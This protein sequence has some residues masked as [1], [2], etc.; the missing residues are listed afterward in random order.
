MSNIHLNSNSLILVCD[1]KLAR[2]KWLRGYLLRIWDHKPNRML[3]QSTVHC[4]A[5]SPLIHSA[6]VDVTGPGVGIAC[7]TLLVLFCSRTQLA[8]SGGA[9]D[10]LVRDKLTGGAA[11][12]PRWANQAGF[13][14]RAVKS[15]GSAPGRV[16]GTLCNCYMHLSYSH[17]CRSGFG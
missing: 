17:I 2:G 15:V 14:N 4:K 16:L 3:S 11:R 9:D 12:P 8:V 1:L 7:A 10:L 6:P 5:H 13:D